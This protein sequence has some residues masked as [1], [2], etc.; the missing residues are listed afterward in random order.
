MLQHHPRSLRRNFLNHH[1][2][3]I[4]YSDSG[5]A[6]HTSLH[7]TST[8]SFQRTG[9]TSSPHPPQHLFLMN[10]HSNHR[11]HPHPH[12]HPSS[13]TAQVS[14]PHSH[15]N[16]VLITPLPP[17]HPRPPT[18]SPS[19]SYLDPTQRI[20]ETDLKSQMNFQESFTNVNLYKFPGKRNLT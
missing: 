10:P 18:P 16:L 9:K 6:K 13:D 1:T 8:I 12:P 5:F 3:M 14:S 2:T 19:P 17:S 20:I 15:H 11:P 4:P 7:P